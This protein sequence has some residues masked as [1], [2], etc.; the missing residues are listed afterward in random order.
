MKNK[1][2][3]SSW[4]VILPL[5]IILWI[6]K[7]GIDRVVSYLQFRGL[8]IEQVE[9]LMR[10]MPR[11]TLN[12]LILLAAVLALIAA[13]IGKIRS[14]MNPQVPGLNRPRTEKEQKM[15]TVDRAGAQKA[16]S[17]TVSAEYAQRT[18]N[19]RYMTQLESYLESGLI[20]KEEYLV[21]KKRYQK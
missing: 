10:V 17:G 14:A 16:G 7:E 2:R 11:E 9:L 19:A 13:I 3:Y 12:A 6:P 1:K 5:L 18:G 20:T 8:G 21:L 4:S 15:H